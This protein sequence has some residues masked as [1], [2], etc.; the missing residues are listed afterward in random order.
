MK[1]LL[2]ILLLAFG[3]NTVSSQK[4]DNATLDEIFTTISDTIQ[5]EQGR[6]QFVI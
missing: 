1:H 3:I 6:W 4:M 2:I 5:G